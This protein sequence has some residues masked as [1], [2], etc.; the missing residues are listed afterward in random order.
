MSGPGRDSEAGRKNVGLWKS[1]D[2]EAAAKRVLPVR[3]ME[4]A[5]FGTGIRHYPST[6]KNLTP[7]RNCF[8]KVLV[9]ASRVISGTSWWLHGFYVNRSKPYASFRL[10]IFRHWY[11]I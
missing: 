11:D 9:N 1:S 6:F 7:A 4:E 8:T 2:Y 3:F 5:T 10:K